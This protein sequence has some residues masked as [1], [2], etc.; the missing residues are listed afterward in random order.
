[1]NKNILVA[2]DRDN[3]TEEELKRNANNARATCA[4][5]L[6]DYKCFLIYWASYYAFSK[7]GKVV[8]TINKYFEFTGESRA[9][10]EEENER[11]RSE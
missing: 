2:M 10:Y 4:A 11:L 9:E 3:K 1:M 7:S 5:G 6:E 8:E